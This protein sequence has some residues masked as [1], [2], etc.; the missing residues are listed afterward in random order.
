MHTV[1]SL[2]HT[3]DVLGVGTH[4]TIIT[5]I[6]AQ[7]LREREKKKKFRGKCVKHSSDRTLMIIFHQ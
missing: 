4:L 2:S 5:Y 6:T 3:R 7:D 1:L